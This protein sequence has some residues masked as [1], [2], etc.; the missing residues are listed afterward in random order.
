MCL[1]DRVLAYGDC[2]VIPEPTTEQLADIAISSAET[3]QQFGIEPR[4]AM[5]S[6]STG[7]SG[8]GAEVEKVRAATALVAERARL[9]ARGSDPI[10][11]GDRSRG[12]VPSCRT[13]RS[14]G[15]PRCSS[16]RT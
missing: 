15:A 1:A 6:Y 16:S 10:R 9:V 7:T 4:I 11:R 3:A 2:A 5:L 12:G 13:H 14:P 8:S